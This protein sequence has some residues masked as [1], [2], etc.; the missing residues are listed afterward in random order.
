MPWHE[1]SYE[2]PPKVCPPG[3]SKSLPG[4]LPR[5][6]R[7]GRRGPRGPEVCAEGGG[8][9]HGLAGPAPEL[10][11]CR[12]FCYPDA[13][14]SEPPTPASSPS[15]R[16]L[17]SRPLPPQPSTPQPFPRTPV[18][19][20][21][22]DHGTCQLVYGCVAHSHSVNCCVPHSH[23]MQARACT[24]PSP[25]ATVFP[26]RGGDM[27][28]SMTNFTELQ[29]KRFSGCG[30]LV[31]GLDVGPTANR[32]RRR[33]G[34]SRPGSGLAPRGSGGPALQSSR[35]PGRAPK[36]WGPGGPGHP[37]AL[38]ASGLWGSGAPGPW[39]SEAPGLWGS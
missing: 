29:T 24:L 30:V 15:P 17:K 19:H 7:R 9:E 2:N 22:C 14:R 10:R 31:C 3:Q 16:A 8:R 12:D 33:E 36:L 28:R 4:L 38:G 5:R 6:R 32:V 37:G 13:C 25:P 34:C 11:F 27:I 18:K 21:A 35:A 23:F 26:R 20:V 1:E 39:G